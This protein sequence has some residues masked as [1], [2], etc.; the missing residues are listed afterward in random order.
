VI[1][2]IMNLLGFLSLGHID[3]ATFAIVSQMKARG[4]PLDHVQ[5][6]HA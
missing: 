1:Y 4:S 5:K 2:L 3:A 6:A